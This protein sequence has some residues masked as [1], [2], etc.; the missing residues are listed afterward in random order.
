MRFLNSLFFCFVLVQ[1]TSAQKYEN[2]RV[3]SGTVLLG[4]TKP[5]DVPALMASLKSDWKV[6]YT[7]QTSVDKTVIFTVPGATVMLG[8]LSYP[9][10]PIE[11]RAAAQLSWLW[12]NATEEALRHKSQLVI[13]IIGSG[14]KSLEL[15]Q[16]FSKVAAAILETA[17]AVG[18]Y[19]N[20]QYLLLSKGFYSSAARNMLENQSLPVYCWVYFGMPG[21]GG[22]Y[23]FGMQDFGL[24]EL[25]IVKSSRNS[26]E[27]HGAIYDVASSILK[28]GTK[29]ADGDFLTT[30]EGLK[31]KVRASKG[32]FL[33]EHQVLQLEY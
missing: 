10:D 5:L 15:H 1:Y 3:V 23:T 33:E 26:S 32:V 9:L 29:P 2:E 11:I 14:A 30:E 18:V 20:S 27:V 28:N 12:P 17:P 21:D 22:A 24:K 7:D 25:E 4:D 31:L 6:N 8:Q 19:M 13:S 16:L